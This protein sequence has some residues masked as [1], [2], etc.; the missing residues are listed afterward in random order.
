M[1]KVKTITYNFGAMVP[2]FINGQVDATIDY[3]FGEYLAAKNRSGNRPSS[4]QRL[5]DFGIKTYAN[6]IIAN[7]AA[8]WRRT[9][10]RS[11]PS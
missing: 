8:S 6:G 4:T 2:S 10:R 9:R 7:N 11:K 1:S 3:Y 5:A